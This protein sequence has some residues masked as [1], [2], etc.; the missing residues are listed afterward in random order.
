MTLDSD[1]KSIPAEVWKPESDLDRVL[2]AYAERLGTLRQE[3]DTALDT[4]LAR[5]GLG[6]LND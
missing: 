3:T 2:A 6:R 5:Y 4:D 1:G